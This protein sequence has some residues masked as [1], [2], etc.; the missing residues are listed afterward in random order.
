MGQIQRNHQASFNLDEVLPQAIGT[1]PVTWTGS[2]TLVGFLIVVVLSGADGE[3]T[4]S[5]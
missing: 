5:G 4:A 1:P 2:V 3:T